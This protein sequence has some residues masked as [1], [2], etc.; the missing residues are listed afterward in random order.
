VIFRNATLITFWESEPLVEGALVAVEGKTIVDFGKLGKL[1]DKYEDPETYD[2][3]GRVVMP[4]LINAH[5]HLYSSLAR[6]MPL[7]GEP[8]RNFPEILEKVWWRLDRA[9]TADDV[10]WSALIGLLDS[11]RAGVTTVIDHHSSPAASAGSL[12][13]I[14]RAFSE[15]GVRGCLAYEVSD[16]DGEA[17]AAAGIDEN[18]RFLERCRA[19]RNEMM[20]GLFGLHASFTLSESTLARAVVCARGVAAGFHVHLAEDVCDLEDA[21]AKYGKSPVERLVDAGALNARSIAA[22]GIHLLPS[23]PQRLKESAA[24]VAHNPQSNAANAVGT[25]DIL[26]LASRGIP[27]AIGTDGFSS[28]IFEELRAAALHQRI[29]AGD[30]RVAMEEAYRAAFFG[31]AD[32]A[33]SIFGPPLG[34]IKPGA[35]ADLVV[36]D[37]TPPTPLTPENLLGHIFFGISRAPL[38]MAVVNGKVIYK[39]GGFPGLDEARL[40]A[41]AQRAARSLWER[42]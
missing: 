32:L 22:H 37:Y 2:L 5:A 23:D 14:W 17:A 24:W 42:M 18:C 1:I 31:N 10:Y 40:R 25:A 41:E 3:G 8:P 38:S 26:A 29:R 7:K 6:G 15:V 33:T 36:L 27:L 30:P 9:L 39:D 20:A 34:R 21:R 12:D 4:G 16:R 13:A 35:R 11:V 19:S 28:S